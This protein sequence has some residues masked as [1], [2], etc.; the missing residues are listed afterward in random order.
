MLQIAMSEESSAMTHVMSDC[1]KQPALAL[2][3]S[4]NAFATAVETPLLAIAMTSRANTISFD[5][6][7]FKR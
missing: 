2:S 3:W 6:W 5:L 4:S 7:V 1:E